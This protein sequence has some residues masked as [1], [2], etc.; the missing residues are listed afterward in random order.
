MNNLSYSNRALLEDNGYSRIS[1]GL[2]PSGYVHI[3]TALTFLQ[4][5]KAVYN[6]DGSFL[7]AYVL[8]LDF[9]RQRE[10]D[11]VS[12]L[13]KKGNCGCHELMREH[14]MDEITQMLDEMACYLGVDH[15]RINVSYFSDLTENPEFQNYMVKLFGS[16]KGRILLKRTVTG[17]TQKSSTLIS[18]IC[19]CGH[20]SVKPPKMV[21]GKDS[22]LL[23][24]E[25]Y[26]GDCDME[27][28][29][30]NLTD[31]RS[32][33][34]HFIVAT[35]RDL[36]KRRKTEKADIHIFGGDYMLPSHKEGEPKVVKVSRFLNGISKNPPLVYVGPLLLY[37]KKRI[38]KSRGSSF[39][40]DRIEEKRSDWAE[41]LN[42]MLEDHLEDFVIDVSQMEKYF[43]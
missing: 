31:P 35:M 2:R 6:N 34:I 11:F 18:P 8:D 19:E 4:G 12:Y 16:K 29:E 21:A 1:V 15:S 7:D 39:T 33:N 27:K 14:T 3:G 17:K 43:S 37:K 13:H 26:N 30:L 28:Y 25:C 36:C 9:D 40:L 22:L 10:K 24:A 41:R 23:R 20:S 5:L 32:L 38:R 42:S